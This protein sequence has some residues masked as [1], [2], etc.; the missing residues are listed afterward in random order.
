[1]ATTTTIGQ[2]VF[3]SIPDNVLLI[4]GEY[5]RQF[6]NTNQWQRIRIGVLCAMTPDS[7]NNITDCGF[8]LGICTG[9]VGMGSWFTPYFVGASLIGTSTAAA[10]RT[11]TYNANTNDPYYSFSAGHSFKKIET[12]LTA[13]ASTTATVGFPAFTGWRKRRAP[14]YV[15]I[16]KTLGGSGAATVTVYGLASG[17]VNQDYRPDHFMAGLDAF[18]TPICNGVTLTVLATTSTTVGEEMGPLDTFNLVWTR[19]QFPLEVSALGASVVFSNPAYTGVGGADETFEQYYP[20]AGTAITNG[21]TPVPSGVLSGGTGW[22]GPIILGGSYSNPSVQIG[23]AG[24]SAGFPDDTFESYGTGSL[25][26]G[27]SNGGIGWGGAIIV[28][29]SYSN[30]SAQIGLAGTSCGFPDDTFESYGT[31][32]VISGSTIN[33]GTG[34]QGAAYVYP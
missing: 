14:F 11:M 16:T 25:Y 29:G 5:L 18:G 21:S 28:G 13:I 24:T 33:A 19:T 20:Y 8:F 23:L 32:T 9:N 27:G 10:T 30:P 22:S 1:M 31:G 4:A 3:A 6:K 7:T 17:N 12:T 15:D 34:W 2:R 26:S